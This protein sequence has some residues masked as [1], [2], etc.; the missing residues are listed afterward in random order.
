[1]EA[2]VK[3]RNIRTA[4]GRYLKRLK[5]L[6][7]GSGRGAV[8]REFQNLEWL[9][10][11]IAHRPSSTNLRSKSMLFAVIFPPAQRAGSFDISV[12]RNVWQRSA[13]R[14][15]AIVCDYMETTLFAI[16]CDLQS[17]IHDRL[18][19]Y[20]NPLIRSP[21]Y[22]PLFLFRRNSHTFS[23]KKTFL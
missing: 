10:P 18:R 16:V 7:S 3:F 17:V 13:L 11:H 4:Y 22:W 9:N 6:P 20:G 12:D 21:C 5:T 1:M 15:F 2:E 23:Y 19:S 8:R 14:S